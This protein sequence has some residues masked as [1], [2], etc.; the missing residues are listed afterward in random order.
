MAYSHLPEIPGANGQARA[1]AE[2]L[3]RLKEAIALILEDR[4]EDG[5]PGVPETVIR[6]TITVE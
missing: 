1:E 5:L 4:R 6:G 3:T 2:A